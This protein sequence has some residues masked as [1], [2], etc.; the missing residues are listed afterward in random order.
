MTPRP[1]RKEKAPTKHQK[2]QLERLESHLKTAEDRADEASNRADTHYQCYQ[3]AENRA[4][5]TD[6]KLADAYERIAYLEELVQAYKEG[7]EE[8]QLVT[9][10]SVALGCEVRDLVEGGEEERNGDVSAEVGRLRESDDH[11]KEQAKSLRKERGVLEERD[12]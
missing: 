11:A 8:Q 5:T 2:R 7:D 4:R 12:G 6:K 10:K 3:D 9:E 1:R